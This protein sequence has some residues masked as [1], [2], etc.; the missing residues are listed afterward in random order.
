[1]IIWVMIIWSH[2]TDHHG[3]CGNYGLTFS[4]TAPSQPPWRSFPEIIS[5]T[6]YSTHV[7]RS[8]CRLSMRR[9]VERWRGGGINYYCSGK[10]GQ[11]RG[12]T[13]MRSDDDQSRQATQ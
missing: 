2:C 11:S 9:E 6:D 7:K 12:R 3:R 8:T 1:M 5:A 13:P 10:S 4:S